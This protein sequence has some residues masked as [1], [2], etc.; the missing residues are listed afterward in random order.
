[1]ERTETLNALLAQ[2]AAQG[3]ALKEGL[4]ANGVMIHEA[5][6]QLGLNII[7]AAAILAVALVIHGLLPRRKG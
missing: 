5:L 6:T 3:E 7:I 4:A 1:M 2:S